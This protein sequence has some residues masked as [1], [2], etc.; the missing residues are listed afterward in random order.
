MSRT[1]C[2]TK[3]CINYHNAGSVHSQFCVFSAQDA[4]QHPHKVFKLYFSQEETRLLPV[5]S[6]G[7]Q[8][9]SCV[10]STA[11]WTELQ[12]QGLSSSREKCTT[13]QFVVLRNACCGLIGVVDSEVL[14]P[15]IFSTCESQGLDPVF[16]CERH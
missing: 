12:A 5:V 9:K 10:P 14:Q 6:G 15:R 7:A 2:K 13:K 4:P 1:R 16:P 11:L 3:L 8:C